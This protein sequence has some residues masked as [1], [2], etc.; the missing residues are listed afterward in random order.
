MAKYYGTIGFAVPTE[1]K[2]GVWKDVM[3]NRQVFGDVITDRR[4]LQNTGDLNDD[5][6][7]SNQLSIIADPFANENFHYIR[8]AEYLKVKWKVTDITVR[9]PRLIL[10]LGGVYNG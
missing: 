4:R 1:K 2:P 7:V 6:T 9:Y 5:I 8:Y 10:T 3:I